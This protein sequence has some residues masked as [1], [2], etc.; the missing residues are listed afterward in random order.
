MF[1]NLKTVIFAL[2]MPLISDGVHAVENSETVPPGIV[3]HNSPAITHTYVGS[4]SLVIMPDGSYVASH[5]YFGNGLSDSYIYLSTDKGETWKQIAKLERLTW[6]TLFNRGKELYL[7]GVSPK[8]TMGYGDFVVRKSLDGGH[9]WTTPLDEATGLIRQ[10]LYHCAPVPIVKHKSSYWRALEQMDNNWGWGPFSALMTSVPISGDLLNANHWTLSNEKRFDTSWRAGAS[11]WLEGNAVIDKQGNVK[12]IL[13]VAYEQDDLAAMVSVTPDGSSI[14]FNPEIDFIHFP[15]GAKKFTI[16][17]DPKSKRYWALSNYVLEKDR[18]TAD[19]GSL[20]NTQVL[21]CSKDIIHWEIKSVL[22]TCDTP[23]LHGFQYVDWQFDGKDIV[24]VSRTAWTDSTGEPPRQH[25]ANYLTFHRVEDFRKYTEARVFQIPAENPFFFDQTWGGAADPVMVWNEHSQEW[26]VYYTQR[27]AY[28]VCEGVEWMHGSTIGIVSSKDGKE[29]KQRGSCRGDEQLSNTSHAVTWWA[30]EVIIDNK[31]LHMYV[32]YVPGVFNSW[33]AKRS[34]KHFTSK[35]GLKWKYQSTL[36]L[37]SEHCIDA[38]VHKVADKWYLW[39]KD[40]ANHN[41]TWFAES[42]DLYH[43]KVVGP[44]IKDCGHEAPFVWEH[45]NKYWMIVDAWE[46]GLR[47][48]S[49]NNG[50]KDWQYSST[51]SGSHPAVY[52]VDGR[53]ILLYHGGNNKSTTGNFRETALY[54]TELS[55]AHGAFY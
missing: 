17:Y 43:W 53:F 32:S 35:D 16:R 7:I 41:Q 39:Y 46:K 44:A 10:G 42:D 33:N 34:I 49:S 26:F 31:L 27:R 52:Q 13:R 55:Y 22:L 51:V 8:C 19:A 45:D 30:P 23:S 9:T 40:E 24:F 38:G 4:P 50:L 48:Y 36:P 15:G 2:S 47:I 14:S 21:M 25:D 29:W 28:L 12:N 18:D 1:K 5:D 54:M 6:G 37:S 20:R 11:A 3:I